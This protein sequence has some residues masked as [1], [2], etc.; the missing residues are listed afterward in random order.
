MDQQQRL[1]DPPTLARLALGMSVPARPAIGRQARLTRLVYRSRAALPL[2]GRPLAGMLRQ[3]RRRN[4]AGQVTGLLVADGTH[5]LQWLEG[6]AEGVGA[7]MRSIARDPR[8][9]SVEIIENGPAEARRFAGW[10]MRLATEGAADAT[11]P[12]LL[13]PGRMVEGMF[14]EGLAGLLGSLGSTGT[15]AA[16]PDR[17]GL[18]AGHDMLDSLIA[19]LGDSARRP[20]A[21]V[22]GGDARRHLALL[23]EPAARRLGDLWGSDALSEFEMTLRLGRLQLLARQLGREGRMAP[24][25]G[26]V[27]RLLVAPMPGEAHALG[28]VLASEWLWLSGWAHEFEIARDDAALRARLAALPFDVLDLSLSPAFL[29]LDEAAALRGRLAGFRAAS[30]RPG[31]R[32]R[33][34]GR[35]FAQQPWLAGLVGADQVAGGCDGMD[36]ALLRLA[37]G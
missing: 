11:C 20:G 17:S 33:L 7:V 24:S 6:P 3:A 9:A 35:I 31:L 36:A 22:V 21:L 15:R 32:I 14:T 16:P 12:A 5:Y 18:P 2:T 37:G 28:A 29:R 8:H 23:V 34:S 30:C 4:Q 10:D 27:P 25:P 19:G 1:A 26:R 13:L